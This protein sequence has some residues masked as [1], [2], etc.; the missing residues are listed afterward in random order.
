MFLY[1]VL[2]YQPCLESWLP[3]YVN[4]TDSPFVIV[5]LFI[6]HDTPALRYSLAIRI[7]QLHLYQLRSVYRIAHVSHLE[8][9]ETRNV[10]EPVSHKFEYLC[11]VGPCH[12][13][14]ARPRFWDGGDGL[15]MWTVA[16]N[17]FSKQLRTAGK[18]WS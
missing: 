7:W 11:Y 15:Q 12:H 2:E 9:M 6:K 16:V 10:I 18:E 13:G 4:L 8:I 1:P 14:V 5:I 17:I 3:F